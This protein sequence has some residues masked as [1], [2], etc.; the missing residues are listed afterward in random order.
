MARGDYLFMEADAFSVQDSQ[1]KGMQAEIAAMD[2]A[3]L[4]N[5]NVDDLVS[6][7]AEKFGIEV[8]TLLED[9]MSLDQ[10]EAQRDVSGDPMRLAYHLGRGGPVMV[11]GAEI[12]VEFP[13]RAIPRCLGSVQAPITL[14]LHVPQFE[15]TSL[16]LA[17]GATT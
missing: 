7:F 14:I 12:F 13:S 15:G 16:L 6:Y 8:P 9:D 2:G 10:R 4:L 1:R 3:R 17:F 11:A 5:T